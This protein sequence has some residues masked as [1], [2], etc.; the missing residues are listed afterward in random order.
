M[1]LPDFT[2][3]KQ[4][5]EDSPL[6][7]YRSWKLLFKSGILKSENQ[8]YE[9][10][11]KTEG[12]HEVLDIN[13]GIYAYNNYNNYNIFGVIK[14]YGKVAI[15]KIGQRSEYAVINTL[16]TIRKEDARGPQEFLNWI[17]TFNKNIIELAK[18]FECKTMHYQDF[19][20]S[21]EK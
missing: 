10:N 12:P 14:Q 4:I 1:C 19:I 2:E 8:N 17:D 20:E 11:K 6:I 13:S 3:F 16:F 7:G 15:H 9:W 5:E 18:R 21:Q